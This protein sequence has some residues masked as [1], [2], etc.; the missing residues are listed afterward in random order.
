M[1]MLL[2]RRE[3][4]RSLCGPAPILGSYAS[5]QER[6]FAGGSNRGA[7]LWRLALSS[8]TK[9]Y[10]SLETFN[11]TTSGTTIAV[12]KTTATSRTRQSHMQLESLLWTA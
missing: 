10:E 8:A 4:V 11:I 1:L 6:Y 2:W 3:L 5:R 9:S 12:V 7:L